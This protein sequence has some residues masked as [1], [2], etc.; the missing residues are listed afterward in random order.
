MSRRCY[1]CLAARRDHRQRP[2]CPVGL[3][4]AETSRSRSP[5]RSWPRSSWLL[6]GVVLT[7]DG[8]T[9]PKTVHSSNHMN[10]EKGH[11]E[12]MGSRE[13]TRAICTNREGSGKSGIA[14]G[15]SQPSRFGANHGIYLSSFG[16]ASL[17][18]LACHVLSLRCSE[19]LDGLDAGL[20]VDELLFVYQWSWTGV[21]GVGDEDFGHA[22]DPPSP[23]NRPAAKVGRRA[24]GVVLPVLMTS[25]QAPGGI[26]S[27]QVGGSLPATAFGPNHILSLV[28]IHFV[29]LGLGPL[30]HGEHRAVEDRSAAGRNTPSARHYRGRTP[31]SRTQNSRRGS[32]LRT[33]DRR[34]FPTGY[35]TRS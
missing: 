18:T 20:F 10:G 11:S 17:I 21:R 24:T 22:G 9:G 29:L 28:E 13:S 12:K 6:R 4:L 32:S 25:G 8:S 31:A 14:A 5:C 26:L 1:R 19:V 7:V 23:A 27:L 3:L 34:G 33:F 15:S 2:D 30:P 16:S 35:A